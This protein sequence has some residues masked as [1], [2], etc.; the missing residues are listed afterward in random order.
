MCIVCAAG[1]QL[2]TGGFVGRESLRHGGGT[3]NADLP[4]SESIVVSDYRALASSSWNRSATFEIIPGK[5][6]FVSFSFSTA[7]SS[8]AATYGAAYAASFAPLTAAQMAAARTAID[9]W[10]RASGLTFVEVAPGQGDLTFGNYDFSTGGPHANAAAYASYPSPGYQS[11]IAVGRS[12]FDSVQLFLHEIGHALGLKHPFEGEFVLSAAEDN[13]ATSVMSYTPGGS[14]GNQLGTL[15]VIAIQ[16]LYGTPDKDGTHVA[17]WS[18]DQASFTLTQVGFA[19]SDVMRGVSGARNIIDAGAG[20]DTIVFGAGPLSQVSAGEGADQI[21]V[22]IDAA[23][24][25]NIDGGAGNDRLILNA[26][27][28]AAGV[29]IDLAN[30][31]AGSRIVS[32][33]TISIFGSR[34]ADRIVTG[35]GAET[36]SGGDGDDVIQT[37]GGNDGIVDTMSGLFNADGGAGSDYLLLQQSYGSAGVYSLAAALAAGARMVNI[38]F[39]YLYGADRGDRVTGSAGVEYINGYGGDD[40]LMGL[41]GNDTIVGD[42]GFDLAAYTGV[43]RQYSASNTRVSGNGEGT[44]TLQGI[45][46]VLFVDGVLSFDRD[47][48]AAQVMRLYDAALNRN[49]DGSGFEAVLDLLEGG[50]SIQQVAGLFLNSPEF[51]ARFGALNNLQF[52]QQM[53]RFALRREGDAAGVQAWTDRLNA[54]TTRTEM[55]VIFSESEE[56]RNLTQ[57]T[58]NAGLWVADDDALKIARMYDATFDRLADSGGLAIWTANLKGGMSMLA[59]ATAFAGSGEFQQRYGAV[60]NEQFIRQMYQF[61]LNR[62]PDAAGLATWVNALNTGTSRAQMLLNFSE[63]A[64]HVALM[65]E[66]WIGGVRTT[67]SPSAIAIDPKGLDDAFVLPPLEE[68]DALP[69]LSEVAPQAWAEAAE[70]DPTG[71]SVL[72]DVVD[73][74][75]VHAELSGPHLARHDLPHHEQSWIL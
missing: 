56:H 8:A 37:G 5:A 34:F 17:S 21:T 65:R 2:G 26:V 38:E 68:L 63:S 62:E 30:L 74:A 27:N 48:R 69:V 55:L 14:A 75:N 71:R 39:V 53:Y 51:Q 6:T 19:S 28:S 54:G 1:L 20:D 45:E 49:P 23:S 18:W 73:L 61:C 4:D 16:H 12:T 67:D 33:E 52:I 44:D 10:G 72:S 24:R 41:G 46:G 32:V 15:D 60:T 7:P 22:H 50:Q 31:A 3:D 70:I 35:D 11:H 43:R 13:F 58:L 25:F 64:E 66:L 59:I 47:G 29:E 36:V 40:V 42:V 57:S 9:L